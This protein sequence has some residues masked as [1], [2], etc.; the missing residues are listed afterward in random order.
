MYFMILR[1]RSG[2][3]LKVPRV[4]TFR[5]VLASHSSTWLSQEEY[6]GV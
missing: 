3:E 1:F 4:V 6:V 2:T 5:S